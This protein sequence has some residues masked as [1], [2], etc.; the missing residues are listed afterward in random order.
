[1]KKVLCLFLLMS[2]LLTAQANTPTQVWDMQKLS[3]APEY[4][5]IPVGDDNSGTKGILYRGMDF[6]GEEKQVF[7]FYST[8]GILKGDE[9]LDKDL[10]VVVCVHGAGGQA[11]AEWV[12]LWASRGYAAIS[13]DLRGFG[14]GHKPLPNGYKYEKGM[15]HYFS[16]YKNQQD[17]WF[18]H[19]VGDVILAHSLVGSF[20]EVNADKSAITGISWGGII[21]S[22]AIGVDLRFKVA[23]PVYGCGDFFMRG[24]MK[25]KVEKQPKWAVE[26]WKTMYN[27]T[28][29][30]SNVSIPVLFVN[31]TNDVHFYVQDWIT[32]YKSVYAHATSLR[33]RFRHAQKYGSVVGEIHDFFDNVLVKPVEMPVFDDLR[34][35][36]SSAR[37]KIIL[38]KGYKLS[39]LYCLDANPTDKTIWS[40]VSVD[41]K[42]GEETVVTIPG[43]YQMWCF[44]A[45]KGKGNGQVFTSDIGVRAEW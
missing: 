6:K 14:L 21:T 38:P 4:E 28:L 26:R 24:Q 1:M 11:N 34:F 18:Y 12:R 41:Y 22:A 42:E 19:A 15:M 32:S 29:R 40:T 20:K 7:A 43:D 17:D 16:C 27:P 3:V 5:F 30:Y 8:P 13:M 36:G 25:E 44:S 23:A 33:L 9:S 35:T 45:A 39:L 10:P 37:C 2:S 31:G